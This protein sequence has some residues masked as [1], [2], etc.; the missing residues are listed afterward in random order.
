[1][2]GKSRTGATLRPENFLL[3]G[4]DWGVIMCSRMGKQG[5][6]LLC[7][8]VASLALQLTSSAYSQQSAIIN[9]QS[10]ISFDRYQVILSRM[11]FGDEA[12]AAAAAQ[13]AAAAKVAPSESFAK[14]L[15]LCAI[16]RNRF[17]DK[18]QAGLMDTVTKKSYFMV[19][20][21]KEDGMELI[22]ADYENEKVLLRKGE[23]EVWMDMGSVTSAAPVVSRGPSRGIPGGIPAPL[24]PAASPVVSGDV[25]TRI[26][27]FSKGPKLPSVELQKKL[28]DYQLDL[29]RAGGQKGPPLPMP[30]TP[31][32]DAQLVKEGVLPPVE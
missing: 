15:R 9:Q 17:T 22:V 11:P 27:D 32:M 14:N 25:N 29:I 30:L 4:S 5:Q 24:L 3:L 26:V 2:G 10:S 23:E 7:V 19:E 12:A 6:L 20:G 13:A 1:M 16:T 18:I 21:D 31:E 28:Q 8:G